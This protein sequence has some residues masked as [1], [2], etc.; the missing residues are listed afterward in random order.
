MRS[1]LNWAGH[2]DRIKGGR[3]TKI[4]DALRVESR[5]RR[6][7]KILRWE[8]RTRVRDRVG[9]ETVGGDGTE[10]R[11]VTKK[12]GKKSTTSIGANPTPDFRD[13]DESNNNYLKTT[14]DYTG[15]RC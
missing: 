15:R 3:R 10:T 8:R 14:Q 13:K 12:K 6:G 7:R 11:S 1:R 9:V 2:V 5:R 4:S